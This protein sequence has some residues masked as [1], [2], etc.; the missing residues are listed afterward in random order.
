MPHMDIISSA[1]DVHGTVSDLDAS[2]SQLQVH[3][4]DPTASLK[5]I[6]T[7]ISQE[8][9]QEK[10]AFHKAKSSLPKDTSKLPPSTA[11]AAQDTGSTILLLSTQAKSNLNEVEPTG[12]GPGESRLVGNT[13]NPG[14][15]VQK[16]GRASTNNSSSSKCHKSDGRSTD[17]S[18]D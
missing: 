18:W 1:G 16:G 12:A 14:K 17:P 4:R 6:E 7:E 9:E 5:H 2:P 11:E 13:Q 3:G 8:K 10:P 15:T